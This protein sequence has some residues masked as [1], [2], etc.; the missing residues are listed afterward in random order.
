MGEK[1]GSSALMRIEQF[2]DNETE[3]VW[4]LFKNEFRDASRQLDGE[5]GW[6]L[7][8]GELRIE[9][10]KKDMSKEIVAKLVADVAMGAS[11]TVPFAASW[12][13]NAEQTGGQLT[14]AG[15]LLLQAACHQ[16]LAAYKEA[17]L[18]KLL[19]PESEAKRKLDELVLEHPRTAVPKFFEM[20]QEDHG[21]EAREL[22]TAYSTMIMLM[23]VMPK[24]KD[25]DV[26]KDIRRKI[27]A[28]ETQYPS[29]E[30]FDHE[31]HTTTRCFAENDK[32]K[33]KLARVQQSVGGPKAQGVLD[34][35]YLSFLALSS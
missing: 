22:E 11:S 19:H 28:G 1:E 35:E 23:Q 10:V 17:L 2:N 8:S 6:M 32:I 21:K 5:L 27:K 18:T 24:H 30:V 34:P 3:Q 29:F 9:D 15:V 20:M 26:L 4:E 7:V 31:K 12:I 13:S 14:D 16:I 25:A 33:R